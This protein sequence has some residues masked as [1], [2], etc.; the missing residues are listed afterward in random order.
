MLLSAS[1]RRSI[2]VAEAPASF[3]GLLRRCRASAQ[4]TQ[5]ELASAAGLSRR[6]VSDLERRV[7]TA[8][9]RDTIRLL[10]DALHLIGPARAE[11]EAAARGRPPV[12]LPA[13]ALRSLP[14]DVPSFTGRLEELQQLTHAAGEGVGT[15]V[16]GGMAGVGKTTFA[17]HAGHHLSGSFP[18]GQ[19][20]LPLHGHTPGRRPID[21]ADAVADLLL[22]IGVPAAQIPQGPEPRMAL[23]RDRL[24]GKRVLL[25]LDDA[26]SSEQV[27]PLLPGTAGSLVLITSRR[28]LT[29][30]DDATAISL[31]T[32]PPDETARLLVR[33]AGRSGLSPADPSVA[34]IARLCGY[35]PLALGMV[36]RQ[37]HHH[38][39]WSASGRAAELAAARDRLELMVTESVTVAA[40]FDLSYGDLTEDQQRL[41]RRLG[42]HPGSDIDAYAAAALDGTDLEAARQGLEALYDQY[43]L[44][45]PGHGRY[46][47]HDLI[48]EH[49]RA[50]SARLDPER[51]R[52]A[53]S[54]RLLAY[55][56]H[57][58]GRANALIVRQTRPALT[59][60]AAAVA[61]VAPAIAGPDEAL[62]WARS[63][64]ANLLACIDKAAAAGRPAYVM[65][66]T[67]GVAG[68]LRRD[69]PWAE[70]ITR[71]LAAVEAAG[72]LGARLGE[73]NALNDLGDARRLIGDH[74]GAEE[75]LARALDIYAEL[76]DRL[77]EANALHDLGTVR[78]LTGNYP[79]AEQA[80]AR[81]LDIYGGL[82]DRRGQASALSELGAARRYPAA[83][84]ALEQALAIYRDL[85]DQRGQANTLNF[86]GMVRCQADDYPA[87]A[88]A[89]EQALAICRQLGDRLGQAHT[90]R[91]LATVQRMTGDCRA[92]AQTLEQSLNI[93]RGLGFRSGEA[94]ALHDLGIVRRMTGD[95]QAAEQLLEQALGLY[96]TLGARSGEAGALSELGVVRRQL[97]DYPAAARATDE[98]LSILRDIGLRESEA[99]TLNERGTL[100]R[101]TGEVADA[102][103][104][105]QQA[106][107]L[108]RDAGS[109]RREAGALA[110][111][112]RC[113]LA[114][115]DAA[116]AGNLLGEAF[117]IFERIG[118]A[119]AP[120]VAAELSRM[121]QASRTAGG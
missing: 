51:D 17:V 39:A 10:A 80:L 59:I 58:A 57:T 93:C 119:E 1:G 70:A 108:A 23:W 68:L 8:P 100:S 78:R 81:A 121:T 35:L 89:Q 115:G 85:A 60:A 41:F 22:T 101:V 44:T 30:L 50:L 92:A 15:H 36:A 84:E 33:L 74:P 52:D 14:R 49:A 73:A 32:L 120:E 97:G 20:F 31:D 43:L 7:A 3:S 46:R 83:A 47:L 56:Q 5:E 19:I 99:Q 103:G 117:A 54:L 37:L 40:A 29:A 55:Y 64:R 42:L 53:A 18:D 2:D 79:G 16:I 110:G 94:S 107:Q 105:H 82:G 109:P 114:A 6:A 112:A 26:V 86:L 116:R 102:E 113:A 111:L 25:V 91:G 11:F 12:T 96:V 13:P 77:G 61:S 4:L 76:G 24:S 98:A 72:Q 95:Y 71:H 66:V 90:L 118:S 62:A 28:H 63:E 88:T 106:L 38:P 67:A 34:E 104:F 27:R 9:H 21:P 75:A 69:G 48:R 65:T 45:E 87:A